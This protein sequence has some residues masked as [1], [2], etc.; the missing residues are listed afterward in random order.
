MKLAFISDHYHPSIGGTQ[1]LCK[2][3]SEFFH[4]QGHEIEVISSLIL[5]RDLNHYPYKVKQFPSLDFSG[6]DLFV[7]NQYDHVFILA[8]LFS[9]SLN[10]IRMQDL[11]K[12][13]LIL[14]LD[15][16]VYSW[17]KN[18]QSGF[19]RKNVDNIVSRIKQFTNVVSFCQDAPV[20]LFLEENNINYNFIPNFSRDTNQSNMNFD[21]KKVLKIGNKKVIFNHGNIESRKNQLN[22]VRSFLNSDLIEDHVLVLLGSPRNSQDQSYL[23]KINNL[24]K[25]DVDKV[26][27]LKGTNNMKLVDSLLQQSD[28][29]ILPSLAEG[30]PLVLLEAMSAGLP[31]VSTPCGGVPGVMSRF[32]S[33][34]VMDDF[35]LSSISKDIR[36]VSNKNSRL[37]WES[38]FTEKICCEK[39]L[40]LL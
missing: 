16:N 20:N 32:D 19:T 28:V 1:M 33:G 12:S 13:T 3:I 27:M 36:S 8:D 6:S 39:Y 34:V 10:T 4:K 38:N 14:N 21:L 25:K 7:N 5:D 26:K 23:K 30:L 18:Q 17:I 35:S 40:E 31:W 15:E 11:K 22:L 29:F 37:D 2:C 24:I 9:T